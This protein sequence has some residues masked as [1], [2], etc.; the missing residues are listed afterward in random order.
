MQWLVTSWV[1]YGHNE[2]GAKPKSSSARSFSFWEYYDLARFLGVEAITNRLEWI[3]GKLCQLITGTRELKLF[4]C[5]WALFLSYTVCWLG[6]LLGLLYKIVKK[7]DV[8][9]VAF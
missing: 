8:A 9:D 5:C 3:A 7:V 6:F 2:S 1:L 4:T